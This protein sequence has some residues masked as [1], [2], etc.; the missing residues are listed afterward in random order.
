VNVIRC[1]SENVVYSIT[2]NELSLHRIIFEIEGDDIDV[3]GWVWRDVLCERGSLGMK[4]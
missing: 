3:E 4:R 2:K 1:N